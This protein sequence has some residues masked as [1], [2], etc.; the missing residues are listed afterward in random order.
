MFSVIK[1]DE[2]TDILKDLKELLWL[3]WTCPSVKAKIT[4]KDKQEMN[5]EDKH[6]YH[7][8]WVLF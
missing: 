7:R 6:L 4:R 3:I 8:R 5:A 1:R 2:V